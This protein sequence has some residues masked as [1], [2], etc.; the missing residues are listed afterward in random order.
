MEQRWP[1]PVRV[2]DLFG[3]PLLDWSDRTLGRVEALEKT[4]A[5]KIR[6]LVKHGVWLGLSQKRVAIPLEVVAIAGRQ[7]A[8]LDIPRDEYFRLPPW[9]ETDA[10]RMQPDEMMRIALYRR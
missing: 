10:S 7:L 4:P 3:L 5:G 1:Q 8:L 9:S 2:G 6:F